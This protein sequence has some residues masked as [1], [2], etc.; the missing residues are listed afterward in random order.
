MKQ[1]WENK[2]K[3]RTIRVD[4]QNIIRIYLKN[5]NLDASLKD[6]SLNEFLCKIKNLSLKSAAITKSK[7]LNI[8][9]GDTVD[10]EIV[11]S[12]SVSDFNICGKAKVIR[13]IYPN[14]FA[15]RFMEMD[16]DNLTRLRQLLSLNLTDAQKIDTDL[17]GII[18]PDIE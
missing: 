9:A 12:M 4:Y 3:R 2:D 7:G 6:A 14:G 15:I 1:E 16:A 5:K 10:F 11:L 18:E 8:K 17:K 13:E